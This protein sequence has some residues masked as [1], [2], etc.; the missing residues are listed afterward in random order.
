[1]RTSNKYQNIYIYI[2]YI[3]YSSC[4]V[5]CGIFRYNDFNEYVG[6]WLFK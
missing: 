4:N 3:L 5:S 1:M 2:L 6:V